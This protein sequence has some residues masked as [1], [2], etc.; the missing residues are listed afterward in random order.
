MWRANIH[1][2]P[3]PNC[4]QVREIHYDEQGLRIGN[5]G[6]MAAA[7]QNIEGFTHRQGIAM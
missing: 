5:T 3:I 1:P 2:R 6:R 7:S 4:L